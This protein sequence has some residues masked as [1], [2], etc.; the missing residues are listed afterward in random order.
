MYD[1]FGAFRSSPSQ[2]PSRSSSR[3][4]PSYAPTLPP[5]LPI[6]ATEPLASTSTFQP[7]TIPDFPPPQAQTQGVAQ[8]KRQSHN[9]TTTLASLP[10]APLPEHLTDEYVLH[11]SVYSYK[12]VHPNRPMVGF[13]PYVLLQTLGEGE[14]GKVK[15]GVHTEYGVEVAIKLIRRGSLEDEA[16]ASKVE[17]EIDVLKVSLLDDHTAQLTSQT[18]KHPNIVRMFDVIDTEKYI[19]IVLE[20]AGGRSTAMLFR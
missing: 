18:L 14:F 5:G 20:Y 12:Q 6:P 15:L 10:K 16:R 4:R 13:G 8:R 19:G 11:P 9:P 1:E 7:Q 3:A 2:G 17:R